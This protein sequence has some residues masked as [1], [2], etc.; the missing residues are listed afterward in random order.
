MHTVQ[1]YIEIRKLMM[2][3][4]LHLLTVMHYKVL[5]KNARFYNNLQKHPCPLICK[6]VFYIKTA[7]I[8]L[9]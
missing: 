4:V 6:G 9:I 2:I 8:P 5:T 3:G 1:V 7:H